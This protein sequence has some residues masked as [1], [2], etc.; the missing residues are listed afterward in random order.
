[1]GLA[2]ARLIARVVAAVGACLLTLYFGTVA[3]DALRLGG[4]MF[5]GAAAIS[6]ILLAALPL[7]V[8]LVRPTS[9]SLALQVLGAMLAFTGVQL[10]VGDPDNHG[11]QAGPFD[12][13]YAVFLVPPAV[14]AS[15]TRPW[16]S[17]V[18][19]G[20]PRGRLWGLVAIGLA[21][22]LLY[23][24]DQALEQ[25]SSWPPAAD[26]HHNSHW[27][28]ASLLALLPITTVATAALGRRCWQLSA[29]SGGGVAIAVGAL[30]VFSPGL[31]SSP[32]RIAAVV[33]TAWGVAVT[34]VSWRS[35][36]VPSRSPVPVP[37]DAAR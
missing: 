19:Q 36:T 3:A 28:A 30:A 4:D 6:V 35:V 32:G 13:A 31:V 15:L 27:I 37:F 26:P 29:F 9:A 8:L 20:A 23:A 14:A 33:V 24:L 11:G 12:F 25:R 18:E 16:R 10:V 34:G 2:P 22:A 5:H 21:P 7:A 1:M 17:P